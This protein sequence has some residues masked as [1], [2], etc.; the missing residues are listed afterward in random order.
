MEH[1]LLCPKKILKNQETSKLQKWH[2]PKINELNRKRNNKN[3]NKRNSKKK[4]C[5]QEKSF[6]NPE[7]YEVTPDSQRDK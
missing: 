3:Q 6:C 7:I 4:N 2:E 1:V 5:Q